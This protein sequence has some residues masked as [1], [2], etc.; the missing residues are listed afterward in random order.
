MPFFQPNLSLERD[1]SG[2]LFTL[3]SATLAPSGHYTAGPAAEGTPKGVVVVPET[4][5][6]VLKIAY[7]GGNASQAVVVIPHEVD[8]K[9][10]NPS[11]NQI[12]AFTTVD[13]VVVGAASLSVPG[14]SEVSLSQKMP[15][16]TARAMDAK[17]N[18]ADEQWSA[19]I[20]EMPLSPRT[21]QVNGWVTVPNPGVL[22]SL[23]RSVPQGFNPAILLLDL[24]TVQLPGIWPTVLMTKHVAY[25]EVPY[26]DDHTHVTIRYGGGASTTVQV[27]KVS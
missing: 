23:R 10:L 12:T 15:S 17:K 11:H 18:P 13:D 5:S 16:L 7:K 24:E 3:K 22:V 6:V 25:D 1:A 9:K 21:L 2:K 4:L 27:K 8:L 19:W 26:F 14:A 20:N